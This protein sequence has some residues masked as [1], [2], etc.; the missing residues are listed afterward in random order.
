MRKSSQILILF[1][2]ICT[3]VIGQEI[4]PNINKD[5]LFQEAVKDFPKKEKKK[6]LKEYKKGNEQTKDAFLFIFTMPR[7]SKALL[8]ENYEKNEHH[9][10]ELKNYYQSIVPNGFIIDIEFNPA[11]ELFN[12]KESIDLKIYK[13]QS[14]GK[15]DV[16]NQ[17]WKLDINSETLSEMLVTVGWDFSTLDSIKYYL[18]KANCISIK[19]GE[20]A[21]IGFARSG[22]GKYFYDIFEKN[23]DTQEQEEFNNGCRYIFYRDN[24]V[25]EYGGGAVGAQCFPDK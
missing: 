11:E 2:F 25:L 12:I 18:D 16:I 21:T 15:S 23:L 17:E 6:F 3:N 24:I 10:I 9:I 5:S 22:L 8:I 14:N 20:F 1:L 7:S 19:N 13:K 4:N